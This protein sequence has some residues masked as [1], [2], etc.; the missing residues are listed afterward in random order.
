MRTKKR[1][2]AFTFIATILLGPAFAIEGVER[3][4]LIAELLREVNTQR[5]LNGKQPLRLNSRLTGAAQKHAE[6]MSENDFFDHLSPDGRGVMERVTK[7]GYHW[8]AIAENIGAGLSSP[9]STVTA[10]M[11]SRGHRDNLLN[12]EFNEV[13]IGYFQPLQNETKPRYSH[14]WVIVFGER[15]R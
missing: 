13:G 5:E 14:Y 3:P 6:N 11:K 9:K 8:R 4:T 2:A 1:I 15:S 10:W 12:G 7:E